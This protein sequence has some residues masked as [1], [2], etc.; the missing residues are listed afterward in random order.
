MFS[1]GYDGLA[2]SHAR[3]VQPIPSD[4]VRFRDTLPSS[5]L[6]ADSSLVSEGFEISCVIENSHVSG[7]AA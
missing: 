7:N 5:E 6:E 2:L 3:H 4:T 1:E